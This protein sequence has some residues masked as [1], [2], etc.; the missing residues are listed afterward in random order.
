M[1]RKIHISTKTS[2]KLCVMRNRSDEKTN[3]HS[4]ILGFYHSLVAALAFIGWFWDKF[5]ATLKTLLALFITA[6]HFMSHDFD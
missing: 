2:K 6:C 5:Q 4:F 3:S 1:V